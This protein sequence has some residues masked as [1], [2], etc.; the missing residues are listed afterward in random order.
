[1]YTEHFAAFGCLAPSFPSRSPVFTVW[2]AYCFVCNTETRYTKNSKTE[3]GG[4]APNCFQEGAVGPASNEGGRKRKKTT[5][6]RKTLTILTATVA[7]LSLASLTACSNIDPQKAMMVAQ[8]MQNFST[9]LNASMANLNN[10]YTPYQ[11]IPSAIPAA[12]VYPTIQL[13]PNVYPA[14]PVFSPVQTEITWLMEGSKRATH[15]NH[16]KH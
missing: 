13:Q 5:M 11:P 3:V 10:S 6:I 9:G 2:H 1:V 7:G 15:R 8:A 4:T 14:N 16:Q 12:P